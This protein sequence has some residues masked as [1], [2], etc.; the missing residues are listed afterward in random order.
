MVSTALGKSP[1]AGSYSGLA[2]VGHP[3]S[4]WNDD[5]LARS[6]HDQKASEKSHREGRGENGA[7]RASYLQRNKQS[8]LALFLVQDGFP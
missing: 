1:E 3:G 8:S 7:F 4:L 5:P 2:G 6:F